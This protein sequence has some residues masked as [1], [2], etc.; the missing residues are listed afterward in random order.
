MGFPLVNGIYVAKSRKPGERPQRQSIG[1][2]PSGYAETYVS[3]PLS[4]RDPYLAR[5]IRTSVP[6]TYDQ[7]FYAENTAADLYDHQASFG[8]RFG[9]GTAVHN[10]DGTHFLL[11]MD[12]PDPLPPEDSHA[13]ARMLADLHLMAMHAQFAVRRIMLPASANL[14]PVHLSSRERETL[15]WVLEGKS[16]WAIGEILGLSLHTVDFHLRNAARK[17]AVHDRYQAAYSAFELGLI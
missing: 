16:N 11:G 7:H 14:P 3:A 2:V 4:Q 8:Y 1:P 15:Q 5:V 10:P 17:L 9:I 12:G 6:V 13:L